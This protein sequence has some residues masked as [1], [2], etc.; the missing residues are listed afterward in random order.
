MSGKT[1]K[2]ISFAAPIIVGLLLL[3]IPV[4][5]AGHLD[6]G[7][8]EI[9]T[10]FVVVL[11]SNAIFLIQHGKD[12]DERFSRLSHLESHS[13]ILGVLVELE[14]HLKAH[15][16]EKLQGGVFYLGTFPEAQVEMSER[17]RRAKINSQYQHQCQRKLGAI[18]R[19]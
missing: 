16:A 10:L 12:I 4:G 17:I 9:I 13:N 8:G 15:K 1:W 6:N 11:I 14:Y 18:Y 5:F 2:I 3:V 7:I 19:L